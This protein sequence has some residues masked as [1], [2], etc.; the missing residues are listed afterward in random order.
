MEKTFRQQQEE[1]SKRI[2]QEAERST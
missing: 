1:I 2:L